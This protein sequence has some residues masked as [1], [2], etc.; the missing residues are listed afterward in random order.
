MTLSVGSSALSKRR[1]SFERVSPLQWWRGHHHSRL[2]P[3]SIADLRATICRL[4]L[5]DHPGWSAAA[6]GDAAQSVVLGLYVAADSS[7]PGWLVDHV[8]SALFLCAAE[9]SAGAAAVLA[10]LRR[11]HGLRRLKPAAAGA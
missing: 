2:F 11:R 7:S 8:G 5:L 1:P 3:D 10:H 9:G 6:R 4:Y